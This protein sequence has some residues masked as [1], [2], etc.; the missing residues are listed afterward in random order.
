[1]IRLFHHAEKL[2]PSDLSIF[3]WGESGTGKEGLAR[4]I[5]Q[6]SRRR[7]RPFIGLD[8]DSEDPERFPSFFFGQAK[9]WSGSQQEMPGIL[10][11]AD[12]GTLFLNN[13]DALRIPVQVRLKRVI[14]RGEYYRENSTEVRKIDVRIIVSSTHDLTSREYKD[15]FSRDLLYHLMVNSIRI[16]ALRERKGDISLIADHFLGEERERKKKNIK[17]FSPEFLEL[18]EGYSFPNNLQELKTI[19]ALAVANEE[20]EVLTLDSLS[21]YIRDR[22]APGKTADGQAFVPRRLDEVISG[23]IR[24]MLEHYG[25]DREKTAEGLGISI[26]EL[27]EISGRG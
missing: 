1:M 7:E 6:A 10:E 12:G 26:E 13:I 14:Q 19:I 2:A 8:A 20:S 22:I 25:G 27:E 23:H 21:S 11:K 18:L 24:L 9:D 4:A 3:I 15:S 16:P 5:H 17:G